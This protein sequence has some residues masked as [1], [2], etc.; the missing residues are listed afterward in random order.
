MNTFLLW[1]SEENTL[2]FRLKTQAFCRCIHTRLQDCENTN[3]EG[4]VYCW[5]LNTGLVVPPLPMRDTQTV[6]LSGR[7]KVVPMMEVIDRNKNMWRRDLPSM[8]F[9]VDTFHLSDACKWC[10]YAVVG[11]NQDTSAYLIAHVIWEFKR[12]WGM[13]ESYS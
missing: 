7:K 10:A 2:F 1:I 5:H 12:G 13:V 6:K 9:K 11:V 3:S 4:H 8:C